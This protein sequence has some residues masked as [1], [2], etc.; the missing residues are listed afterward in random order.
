MAL[1]SKC[2]ITRENGQK[3]T[4]IYPT[5]LQQIIIIGIEIELL[6][7]ANSNKREAPSGNVSHWKRNFPVSLCWCSWQ[8]CT[9]LSRRKKTGS[10]LY[11]SLY[12]CANAESETPIGAQHH[13]LELQQNRRRTNDLKSGTNSSFQGLDS[14]TADHFSPAT[15]SLSVLLLLLLWMLNRKRKV[16]HRPAWNELGQLRPKFGTLGRN[17]KSN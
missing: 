11:L 4:T 1:I 12:L 10:V 14:G 5:E 8:Q 17:S 2:L 3:I 13:A 6:Q 7:N 9:V 15:L 16:H